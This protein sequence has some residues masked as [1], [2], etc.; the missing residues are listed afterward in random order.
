[1]TITTQTRKLL[2]S[3]AHDMCA[4]CKKPLTEFENG[5]GLVLGEEAHI[6]GR[7]AS[8]PRGLDG[9]RADIDSFDNLILLCA[10]D[11]KRI[12]SLPQAYTV[13]WLRQKK[14]EHETWANEKL[15]NQRIRI[16][17][18]PGED[19]IPLLTVHTGDAVWDLVAGAGVFHFRG[20]VDEEDESAVDA[21]DSFL[22]DARDYGEMH[23]AIEDS[24]FGAVRVAKRALQD[25]LINLWSHDLFVFG[26]TVDRT[27]TGG[28]GHPFS[29]RMATLAVLTAQEMKGG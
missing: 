4:L 11:H 7:R 12:D 15:T 26:R 18:A 21:A 16:V 13:A 19:S 6:V 10:D 3:R 22:T 14:S 9:D 8:G 1:M 5:S 25:H 23:G 29:L 24:G 20:P 17:P 27:V 2:W 28:I